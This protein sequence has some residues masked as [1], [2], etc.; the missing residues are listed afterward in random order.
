MVNLCN[1]S[2]KALEGHEG[3]VRFS[4]AEGLETINLTVQDTG[5]GVDPAMKGR[6]FDPYITSGP[7]EGLGLGLAISK[8]I[9]LDHGGDLELQDGSGASFMLSFKKGESTP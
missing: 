2:A 9:M 1:N 4:I 8:K 5:P 7:G 6:L 3:I